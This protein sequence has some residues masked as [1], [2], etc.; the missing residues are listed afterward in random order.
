[1]KIN[2]DDKKLTHPVIHNVMGLTSVVDVMTTL[3]DDL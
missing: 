1:M 3:M 2:S